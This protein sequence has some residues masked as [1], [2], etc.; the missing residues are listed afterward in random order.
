MSMRFVFVVGT[1]NSVTLPA[2]VTL[3]ILLAR[4]S[5]THRLP[6][7]PAVIPCGPAAAVGSGYSV[8]IAGGSAARATAPQVAATQARMSARASHRAWR[9]PGRRSESDACIQ[10][11]LGQ[12]KAVTCF[13]LNTQAVGG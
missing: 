8:M 3:A 5:A 12:Q 2:C 4:F 13:Y 10:C 9:P 1:V 7:G 11:L 6:L